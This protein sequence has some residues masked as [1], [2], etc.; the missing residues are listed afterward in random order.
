MTALV[1]WLSWWIT[2]LMDK[3]PNTV[4][5][6][7]S[8]YFSIIYHRWDNSEAYTALSPGVLKLWATGMIRPLFCHPSLSALTSPFPSCLFSGIVSSKL[9][10]I[11]ICVSGVLIMEQGKQIQLGTMMLQVWS[12]ASISRLKIRR[13][14]ELWCR[15]QTWLRSG[16]AVALA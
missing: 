7:T 16:V 9:I 4:L 11:R 15:L 1:Q 13:C 3:Q 8:K 5:T 14:P 6:Y 12:L 2:N 10:C